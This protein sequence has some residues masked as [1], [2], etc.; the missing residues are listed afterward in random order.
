MRAAHFRGTGSFHN[1]TL[2][3]YDPCLYKHENTEG[4]TAT[5]GQNQHFAQL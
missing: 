4:G 1:D 2:P 5:S 3:D